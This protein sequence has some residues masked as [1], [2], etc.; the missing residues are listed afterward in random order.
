[1]PSRL[2][3]ATRTSACVIQADSIPKQTEFYRMIKEFS[4]DGSQITRDKMRPVSVR[5]FAGMVCGG[6]Y[7]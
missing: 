7:Q 4:D 2:L 3:F 6:L 1:M 5:E